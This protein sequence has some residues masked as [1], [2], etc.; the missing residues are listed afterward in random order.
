MVYDGLKQPIGCPKEYE[1]NLR[2]KSS[3]DEFDGKIDLKIPIETPIEK[4]KPKQIDSSI[5]EINIVEKIEE[6][7]TI[8][9]QEKEAISKNEKVEK[10][11]PEKLSQNVGNDKKRVAVEYEYTPIKSLNTFLY[12]WKIKARVTKK[13]NK[14]MWRNQK[15]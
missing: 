6:P 7:E 15:G 5:S 3:F 8:Q 14:K 2:D 11:E 12:D 13:P 10:A 4:E 1:K 9:P